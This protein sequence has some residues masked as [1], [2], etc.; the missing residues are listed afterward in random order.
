MFKGLICGLGLSECS[1]FCATSFIQQIEAYSISNSSKIK[2]A[3]AEKFSEPLQFHREPI[4]WH[5]CH[6]LISYFYRRLEVYRSTLVYEIL[7][8]STFPYKRYLV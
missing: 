7:L 1:E 4:L 8:L 2:K 6:V 3:N 5:M